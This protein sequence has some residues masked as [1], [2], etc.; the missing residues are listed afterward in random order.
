MNHS[1]TILMAPR[2]TSVCANALEEFGVLGSVELV[3]FPLAVIPLER[4]LLS[5]ELEAGG[6]RDIFYD[7]NYDP[8]T[9]MARALVVVQRI[10][11]NIPRILGKGDA[12]R[13]LVDVLARLRAELLPD[14]AAPSA[15]D[16]DGSAVQYGQ[17]DSVILLDRQVDMVTPLCTQLTYEGLID[18]VIGIKNS[19]VEV[20][21][22]LTNPAPPTPSS[23]TAPTFG[24]IAAQPKK[25]K[26][27]LSTLG[28]PST[29]NSASGAPASS[30]SSVGSA[31]ASDPLLAELRDRNFATI[32]DALHRI[33]KRINTDYEE[34]HKAQTVGQMR[35]FVGRLSGLQAEHQALRLHTGLSEQ[36]MQTTRTDEFNRVLEIQQSKSESLVSFPSSKPLTICPTCL[37]PCALEQI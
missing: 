26:H 32:G 3:E 9:E 5:L 21:S 19:F 31:N 16:S 34:R 22:A 37:L 11:G 1:Y 29:S 25:K 28:S 20:D 10:F 7:S 18:E 33:A 15:S 13:R 24:A 36:I 6:Y 4:D 27:L 23:S 17:I 30:S 8:I 2:V 14:T 12:S 35:E